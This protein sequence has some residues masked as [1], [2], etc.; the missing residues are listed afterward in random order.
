MRIAKIVSLT[1]TLFVLVLFAAGAHAQ[2]VP[3]Y[4]PVA[5]W[6]KQLP[7]NWM[8]ANAPAMAI[9]K[10]DHI[11]IANRPAATFSR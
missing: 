1:A 6:P 5:P 8:L 2:A 11:W 9:D 3:Q 4:K 7:N 10:N